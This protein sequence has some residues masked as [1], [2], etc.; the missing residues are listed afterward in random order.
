MKVS[1]MQ[2]ELGILREVSTD[3]II[4]NGTKYLKKSK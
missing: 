1:Q 3:G 4:A 2:M